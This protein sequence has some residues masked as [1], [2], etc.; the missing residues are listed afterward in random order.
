MGSPP[1]PDVPT[2]LSKR[3]FAIGSEAIRVPVALQVPPIVE[4]V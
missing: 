1:A 3:L 4:V 2:R